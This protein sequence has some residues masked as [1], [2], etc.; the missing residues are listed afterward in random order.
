MGSFFKLNPKVDDLPDKLSIKI[1]S[2]KLMVLGGVK[3]GGAGCI[4]PESTLLK[5]L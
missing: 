4:C 2:V 5:T 3:K 1:G